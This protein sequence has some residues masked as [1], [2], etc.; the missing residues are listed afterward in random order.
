MVLL[1]ILLVIILVLVLKLRK[2]QHE[3]KVEAEIVTLLRREQSSRQMAAVVEKMPMPPTPPPPPQ[4]TNEA[5]PVRPET[6]RVRPF[7]ATSY[8][9]GNSPEIAQDELLSSHTSVERQLTMYD[10]VDRL[11]PS[12][13]TQ[14]SPR[15]YPSPVSE[16]GSYEQADENAHRDISIRVFPSPPLDPC[17]YEWELMHGGQE[18]PFPTSPGSRID[19][20]ADRTNLLASEVFPNGSSLAGPTLVFSD[21]GGH[22]P[23]IRAESNHALTFGTHSTH[24]HNTPRM[25]GDSAHSLVNAVLQSPPTASM[26]VVL[27]SPRGTKHTPETDLGSADAWLADDD[28][29]YDSSGIALDPD[30]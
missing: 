20:N 17:E 30:L 4:Y 24:N 19:R 3:R 11:S 23:V 8:E 22:T 6:A 16:Y 29:L 25:N 5:L 18:Q 2:R 26:L 1:T 28:W 12:R 27:D 7:I 14:I 21:D 15:S 13:I 9:N 10:P